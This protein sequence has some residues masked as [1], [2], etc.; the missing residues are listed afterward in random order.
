MV[1]RFCLGWDWHEIGRELRKR[2]EIFY[3]ESPYVVSYGDLAVT[4]INFVGDDVRSL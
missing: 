3:L 1:A 4:N 2:A